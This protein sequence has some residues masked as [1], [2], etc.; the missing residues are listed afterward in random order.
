M[1]RD[2]LV[3]PLLE[4][5]VF[6]IMSTLRFIAEK[7]PTSVDLAK[8]SVISPLPTPRTKWYHAIVLIEFSSSVVLI[9]AVLGVAVLRV[10][11]SVT[12]T[13]AVTVIIRVNALLELARYFAEATTWRS[14]CHRPLCLRIRTSLPAWVRPA[15]SSSCRSCTQ[16]L[17]R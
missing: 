15:A 4:S 1:L 6:K 10:S 8:V 14:A 9:I 3:A 7:P 2:Q 5:R 11:A 16:L 12:A 17:F 13:L